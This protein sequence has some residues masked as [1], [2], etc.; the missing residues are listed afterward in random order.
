MAG[1]GD[2]V[3]RKPAAAAEPGKMK[4]LK[5]RAMEDP[6]SDEDEMF[7]EKSMARRLAKEQPDELMLDRNR[8]YVTGAQWSL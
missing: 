6:I 2:A 8:K 3:A 4:K 1:G 7:A 5:S